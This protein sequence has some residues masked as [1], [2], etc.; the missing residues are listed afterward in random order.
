M[1]REEE[2]FD[3]AIYICDAINLQRN[4]LHVVRKDSSLVCR[5]DSAGGLSNSHSVFVFVYVLLLYFFDC[6][7]IFAMPL[8]CS[9]IDCM[10]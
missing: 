7:H 8:I 1:L 3:F 2:F 5:R 6:S 4:R 10:L 9:G